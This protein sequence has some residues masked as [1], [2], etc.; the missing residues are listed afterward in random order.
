VQQD[1]ALV[2]KNKV[3]LFKFTDL[4]SVESSRSVPIKEFGVGTIEKR[5]ML[6]YSRFGTE[7]TLGAKITG[8][9]GIQVMQLTK[10]SAP[11]STPG[12]RS[13]GQI[14]SGGKVVS[15]VE[16]FDIVPPKQI[17]LKEMPIPKEARP[18]RGYRA[19]PGLQLPP[20]PKAGTG[21]TSL[22]NPLGG[23][24][25]VQITSTGTI[26][27]KV[28]PRYDYALYDKPISVE[29]PKIYVPGSVK[30]LTAERTYPG[31]TISKTMEKT[32]PPIGIYATKT[33]EK[34]YP[35]IGRTMDKT[36]PGLTISKV[37]ERTYPPLE[38]TMEKTYPP[39]GRFIELEKTVE[40]TTTK[41]QEP[42]TPSKVF[43]PFG[44]KVVPPSEPPPPFFGGGLPQGMFDTSRKG[45][46]TK[47][48]LKARYTPSLTSQLL[49]I[50]GSVGKMASLSGFAIRPILNTRKDKKRVKK[51]YV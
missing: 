29:I 23:Q 41:P 25:Q 5:G 13:F 7:K 32:Y 27:S 28:M 24:S 14:R 46:M 37:M 3:G 20:E 16:T 26:Q 50:R 12:Y 10:D 1:V 39:I 34:T 49:N 17:P 38:K 48:K 11:I 31:L 21:S 44:T 45:S 4:G 9:E 6:K 33:I 42:I 30:E 47:K 36:A 51:F 19:P 40:I 8:P 15:S 18:T 22:S 2:S 43:T 35:P